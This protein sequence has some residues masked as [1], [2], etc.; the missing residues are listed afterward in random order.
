MARPAFRPF[1]FGS[2]CRLAVGVALGSSLLLGSG[3][4]VEA[5]QGNLA[6]TLG[7]S[8]IRFPDANPSLTPSIAAIENPI[9]VEVKY[10][11]QGNWVLTVIAGGDLTSGP[12]VIPISRVRWTATGATYRDGT[13]SK[14][15]AQTVG[16]GTRNVQGSQGTLRFTLQNSWAYATGNYAQVITFTAISF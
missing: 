15:T 14:T 1:Q 8:T 7:A 13:M 6:L 12:D 2:A 16:S 5:Q 4:P 10:T 11:G 9:P 3:R